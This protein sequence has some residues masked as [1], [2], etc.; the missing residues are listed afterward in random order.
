MKERL[1]LFIQF[2]ISA[3]LG[4]LSFWVFYPDPNKKV[5]ALAAL[6]GGF[7]GLWLVMYLWN[8]LVHGRKAAKSL[9]MSGD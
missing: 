7:G 4:C 5:P 1:T 2:A 9:T 3:G 8:L 6:I